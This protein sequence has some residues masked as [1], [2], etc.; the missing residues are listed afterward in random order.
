MKTKGKEKILQ[1]FDCQMLIDRYGSPVY[2]YDAEVIRRQY[3]LIKSSFYELPNVDISY[4]MKALNNPHILELIKKMGGSIDAVSLNE[5]LT[6]LKVGF[7]PGKIRYTPSGVGEREVFSVLDLG[8]EIS[9]GDLFI[10]EKI[11]KK[12]PVKKIA[13]RINPDIMAGGNIKISTAHKESKFG[14]SFKRIEDARKLCQRYGMAVAGL[15]IHL[16]SDIHDVEL[17]M[18]SAEVLFRIAVDFENLEYLNFGGGFKVNYGDGLSLDMQTLGR[19]LSSRFMNFC[20]QTG[21]DI[22]IAFEPGKFLV[23]EAGVLLATVSSIKQSD[24][25]KFVFLDTG[26][27]HLARPMMYGAYHEIINCKATS[28]KSEEYD[29]VGYLCEE[30]TL[31]KNR[32]LPKVKIGDILAIKNAGAYGYVMASNYNSRPRPAEVLIEGGKD[33]LI[34]RQESID[35]IW[36]GVF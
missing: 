2:V 21:K 26:F 23:S 7:A 29:I 15:H 14:I 3:Q 35:D 8:V 34:R 25:K 18:Q 36:R 13:L 6:A 19:R 4:A 22:G 17:F 1:G 31:G 27:N 33:R 20:I 24:N 28:G 12:F 11:G 30:D 10:L 9:I 5:V 16:G 32:S